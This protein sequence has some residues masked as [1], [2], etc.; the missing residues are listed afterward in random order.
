MTINKIIKD[1][2]DDNGIPKEI[3][4]IISRFLEIEDEYAGDSKDKMYEQ[5]LQTALNNFDKNQRENVLKWC[6]EYL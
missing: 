1:S 6:K 5:T 4:E 2:F 3:R